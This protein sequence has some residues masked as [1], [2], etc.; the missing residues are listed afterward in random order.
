MGVTALN[1]Y[2]V[3]DFALRLKPY[4]PDLVWIYAGHNEFFG[5]K[6]SA[7]ALSGIPLSNNRFIKNSTIWLH[8]SHLFLA[9]KSLLTGMEPSASTANQTL[10]ARA[11]SDDVIPAGSPLRSTTFDYFRANIADILD[12]YSETDVPIVLSTLLSNLR[13][14]EPLSDDAKARTLYAKAVNLEN[15]SSG[16][17]DS[18]YDEF[19]RAKDWDAVPFRAPSEINDILG[20]LAHSD[21]ASLFDTKAVVEARFGTPLPGDDLF[22]DHLHFNDAGHQIMAEAM[23]DTVARLLGLMHGFDR[24]IDQAEIPIDALQAA[25][26]AYRIK[27][28]KN[29]E[30]FRS[31][32]STTERQRVKDSLRSSYR[33]GTQTMQNALAF[34]KNTAG[35]TTYY[36]NEFKK[37]LDLR[38]STS[39]LSNL[40][41]LLYYKKLEEAKY[42]ESVYPLFYQSQRYSPLFESLV[43]SVSDLYATPYFHETLAALSLEQQQLSKSA[44]YLRI[45]GQKKPT[46]ETLLY[47]YARYYI[48]TGDTVKAQKYFNQYRAVKNK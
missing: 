11:L 43:H 22:V 18:L 5:V 20:D 24:Q 27:S 46:S 2:A 6:G 1:S 16:D 33:N 32:P 15:E 39:A 10:M 26:A 48:L 8:R 28:L 7:S 47:N 36:R 29:D 34:N 41:A 19:Q 23:A 38:D 13:D 21:Q 17:A 37:K 31:Y 9:L 14:Q 45:A 12:S 3:R 30:P 25:K 35:I 42:L 4:Q 40:K 44:L